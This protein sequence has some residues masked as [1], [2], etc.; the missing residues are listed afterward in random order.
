MPEA[1]RQT[2]PVQTRLTEVRAVTVADLRASLLWG[3]TDFARAP[4]IG[5]AIGALFTLVGIAITLALAVWHLPWMIYP[6]AIGFPLIGPFAAVGLYE[7][8][9]RLEAGQRPDWPAVLT[10]IWAQR[11]RE[12]SWMAFTMLFIFW[13][14][15]YQ[16]RLLM[17]LTLGRMSYATLDRFVEVVLT[18]PQGWTFLA[19]G[20]VVGAALSLLLF[21][22]T[23][24]AMPLLLDREVDFI[25][26]MITSVRAVLASPLVMLGWG[27]VVT[28]AV[29]A[30]CLPFF[31]GLLIVLPVLGH[32]TWHL[33]RR[34]VAFP[35]TQGLRPPEG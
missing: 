6:F 28:I 19:V 30:A 8:S 21:S 24:I 29:L 12:I 20:H 26:A 18:T 17:A 27:V 11:R 15:M 34:A 4:A 5:L 7:V 35:G 22:V 9:R 25:T 33:Y 16:V 10:V 2:T 31:V 3:A 23:V 32:A 13:M 14:W 1:S